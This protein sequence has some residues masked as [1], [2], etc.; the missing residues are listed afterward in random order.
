MNLK[1]RNL[2]S[3]YF[4]VY[5]LK[6][7]YQLEY[8]N[9]LIG[10]YRLSVCQLDKCNVHITWSEQM[11]KSLRKGVRIHNIQYPNQNL[12]NRVNSSVNYGTIPR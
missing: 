10:L 1:S 2:I 7:S 12:N 3:N 6:F 11:I 9:V 8:T 5:V 4:P